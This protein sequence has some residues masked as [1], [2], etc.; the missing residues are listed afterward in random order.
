MGTW[1]GFKRACTDTRYFLGTLSRILTAVNRRYHAKFVDHEG[2]D[3]MAADWDNLLILDGCRADLFEERSWLVGD[4]EERISQASQSKEFL[5]HNF[6]GRTLHDT[7]YI[8][9]NP[10]AARLP[11]DTFHAFV[12]LFRTGWDSDLQ[13]VTPE[14][15]A[16]ATRSIREEYPNKRIVA[17]FMQPHY[18][19]IGEL[20]RDIDRSSIGGKP[21]D[22]GTAD[23]IWAQL[24]Y[25][26]N[27]LDEPLVW[28]AYAENLDLVLETVEDLLEEIDGRSVITADHGNMIGDRGYPIPVPGFG[29]PPEYYV[30]P[31]VRVPWLTVPGERRRIESAPP[32][33]SARGGTEDT[34]VADRLRSLGYV[35]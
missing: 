4:Y 16:A 11:E 28:R 6:A 23:R 30:D 1:S 10:Y 3:V 32:D 34:D 8:S 35:E 12:D 5:E 20:G 7:V 9:A 22:E 25:G 15:V 33:R 29:H 24:M 21:A 19:F 18:P 13:T 14:T 2:M 27:E 26:E 17:H 31:L